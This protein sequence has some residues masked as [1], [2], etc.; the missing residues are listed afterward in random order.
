MFRMTTLKISLLSAI[1]TLFLLVS[2][3]A[4]SGTASAHTASAYTAASCQ[5]PACTPAPAPHI[6]VYNEVYI[7]GV[8]HDCRWM[9]VVGVWLCPR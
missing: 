8:N 3:L 2:M 1:A 4:S 5:P 9:L 7:G 6:A